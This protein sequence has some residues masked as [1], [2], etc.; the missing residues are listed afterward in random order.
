MQ[1]V[2]I[3]ARVGNVPFIDAA[4]AEYLYQMILRDRPR[5]ILELG[6]AHGT[7]TCYMAA[8]L[9]ETG[10]GLITAVDLLDMAE[11]FQPTP[12]QQLARTGL[13]NFAEIIRT[14]TGYNWFLHDN[15]ARNTVDHVCREEYD[16]CIIDGAKNWTSE[17]AAFFFVDK[18]L[19]PGGWIIFDDYLWAAAWAE[20]NL[21]R[22]ATDGIAN[23][24]L[25][26]D[27]IE[28]PQIR[29]V[30][31]LLVVPHPN[32]SNFMQMGQWALAQKTANDSKTYTI[33]HR[34][35]DTYRDVIA[36]LFTKLRR[37]ARREPAAS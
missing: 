28:T 17:G 22:T 23:R 32:Y 19:K 24:T 7:A 1:F 26:R 14:K 30:F 31:E 27:E 18:L 2:E 33:V 3:H 34:H 37:I 6:I 16:L 4:N 20:Q 10:G 11:H 5:R 15:I 12:E 36:K 25:S 13:A 29:E 35:Q 21:G 8:A 9:H